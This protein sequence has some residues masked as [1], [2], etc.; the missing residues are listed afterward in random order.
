MK[1]IK[2]LLAMGLSGVLILFLMA[3][4]AFLYIV[5]IVMMFKYG[6]GMSFWSLFWGIIGVL[7]PPLGIARGFLFMF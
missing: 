1:K 7:F 5:N 2:E 6:G 3:S 4:G